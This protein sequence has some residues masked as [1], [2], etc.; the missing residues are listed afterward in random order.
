M[1]KLTYYVPVDF[2]ECSLNALQYATMLARF[3][4]GKVVL[5]HV[6]DL[7]EVPESENPVVVSWSLDRLSRKVQEKMKSLREI[8]SLEGTA[9]EEEI[10]VGNVRQ[11]LLKQ[12]EKV[13]PT[14]IVIGRNTERNPGKGSLLTFITKNT[15]I[16]VLVVPG[17]HNPKVPN[18][19]VLATDMKSFDLREFEPFIDIIR[20]T[21][22]QLS[23]L[24]IRGNQ[25]NV[26]S[27]KEWVDKLNTTYN[28]K[29]KVLQP[30]QYDAVESVV[31]YVN[32]NNV[33]LLCTINRNYSLLEKLFFPVPAHQLKTHVEVP[34]L[35]IRE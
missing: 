29:A 5:G 6:I 2:S 10:L 18:K 4:E 16:P 34:V 35:L 32:S 14:V 1:K 11:S 30:E 22:Q 17:S 19:A 21:S 33:D 28:I 9:V 13:R 23:V 20:K 27:I 12:I 8:I 31:D 3:A 24:N 26:K 7:E 25:S 15:R